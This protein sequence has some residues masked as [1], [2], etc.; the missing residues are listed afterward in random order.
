[1]IQISAV[2]DHCI[3]ADCL[4]R[5][6]LGAHYVPQPSQV[7]SQAL[8]AAVFWRFFWSRCGECADCLL[9]GIIAEMWHAERR[10]DMRF[11]PIY[12]CEHRFKLLQ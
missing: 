10:R 2:S 7:L 4:T 1:M 12:V 6:A 8:K 9:L 5:I 11:V 3:R